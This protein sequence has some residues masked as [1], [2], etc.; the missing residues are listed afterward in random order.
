MS[1]CRDGILH[2]QPRTG[3]RTSAAK[4]SAGLILAAA[5]TLGGCQDYYSTGPR[6][7]PYD[8]DIH[9]FNRLT[10]Q[11]EPGSLNRWRT[12]IAEDGNRGV[13]VYD[14]YRSGSGKGSP[15]QASPQSSSTILP[16]QA[17]NGAS[18]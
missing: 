13:A 8:Y 3:R 15:S 2:W 7:G 16:G 18:R 17:S 12:F 10:Q 14:K 5:A 4:L 9:R 6:A 1:M 11:A